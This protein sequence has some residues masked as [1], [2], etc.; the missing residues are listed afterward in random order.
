LPLLESHEWQ[1]LWIE[2]INRFVVQQMSIYLIIMVV[3]QLLQTMDFLQYWFFL[4]LHCYPL[5]KLIFSFTLILNNVFHR[6]LPGVRNPCVGCKDHIFISIG[7]GLAM[8][9]FG[10]D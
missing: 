5:A 2:K 3:V 1:L 8:R 6:Y 9:V 4:M 10:E 7:L